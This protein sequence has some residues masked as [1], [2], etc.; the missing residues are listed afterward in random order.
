MLFLVRMDVAIP[1]SMPDG[2]RTELLGRERVASQELQES[3]H[4]RHLWRV[5]GAFANYSIFDVASND[6]LHAILDS[7]PIAPYSKMSVIPLATH[8]VALSEV[9]A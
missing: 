1:L 4:W 3:G 6:E 9:P 7:L 8:P 2:E 5:V